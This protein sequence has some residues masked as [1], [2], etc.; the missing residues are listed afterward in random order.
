KA[1]I[2]FLVNQGFTEIILIGHST[3]ANKVCYYSATQKNDH[4]A[5]IVLAGPMSDRL[6]IGLDIKKRKK[7]LT[8]MHRLVNQGKGDALLL[9]YHYFPITPRRFLSLFE[10]GSTEDTFDY[11]DKKPKL[12]YFS[13]IRLPLFVVFAGNDEYADR[14]M[15]EIQNIFDKNVT[16]KHYKSIIVPGALHKFNGKEKRFVQDVVTWIKTL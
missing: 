1:G 15:Q 5:G 12:M 7:V 9:D 10:P 4:V 2:K 6:E 3:G 11:G 16:S 13:K 14:P 8:H